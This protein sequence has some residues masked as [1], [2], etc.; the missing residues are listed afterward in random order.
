MN[1]PLES[2]TYAELLAY[3]QGLTQGQQQ[4]QQQQAQPPADFLTKP[5]AQVTKQES[6]DAR[7]QILNVLRQG[8]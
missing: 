5:T 4:Q 7:S 2:M 6:D 1:K 8:W 3:T